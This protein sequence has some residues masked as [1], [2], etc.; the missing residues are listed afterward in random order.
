MSVVDTAGRMFVVDRSKALLA[1][2]NDATALT[3]QQLGV[4]DEATGLSLGASSAKVERFYF[5]LGI[6]TP[7]GLDVIQTPSFAP[8]AMSVP[9][10]DCFTPYTPQIWSIYNT[11]TNCETTYGLQ[12]IIKSIDSVVAQGWNPIRKTYPV[13][14]MCCEDSC[15]CGPIACNSLNSLP[16]LQALA[17]ANDPDRLVDVYLV[18]PAGAT[19]P[20]ATRIDPLNTVA[21]QAA[22]DA[23]VPGT[24]LAIHIQ[25][26]LEKIYAFCDVIYKGGHEWM[27]AGLPAFQVELAGTVGYDCNGTIAVIQDAI[28]PGMTAADAAQQDYFQQA[29]IG[30][31]Q[32]PNVRVLNDGQP[33]ANNMTAAKQNL[34]TG[35]YSVI[36]LSGKNNSHVGFNDNDHFVNVQLALNCGAGVPTVMTALGVL[37]A[38]QGVTLNTATFTS[39]DGCACT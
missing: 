22:I 18:A 34:L 26:R 11:K 4:F 23:L 20:A 21:V 32:L 31:L 10:S 17:I 8:G 38:N 29:Y 33:F 37:L 15:E 35:P 6:Q 36:S 27:S 39:I 25:P 12:V 13:V 9:I 19:N 30:G 28:Y 24:C 3:A 5:G 16:V 2:G 1:A 14:T 7:A